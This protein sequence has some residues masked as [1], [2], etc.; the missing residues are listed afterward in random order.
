MKKL[1]IPLTILTLLLTT[2]CF[3]YRNDIIK[4]SWSDIDPPYGIKA[5]NCTEL[6]RTAYT[7]CHS[8]DKKIPL[9]TSY[10]L[11]EDETT[12]PRKNNF[13]PD[14]DLQPG[15]RAELSDYKGSGY[16]RGHMAPA[17]DMNKTRQIMDESF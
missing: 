3:R 9:W 6:K 13:K 5:Q 16:D 11:Y 2:S 4:Q 14:P 17:A 10:L 1:L 12:V 8:P 15:Q 7:T